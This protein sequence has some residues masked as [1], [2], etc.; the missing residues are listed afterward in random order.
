[1]MDFGKARAAM[2]EGQVRANDVTDTRLQQAMLTVPRELF[3]PKSRRSLA[4]M[5]ESVD[6]GEGR[7]L[8]DPRTF[9]KLIQALDVRP[10]DVVLDIGCATGYGAAVLSAMAETVIGL[11]NDEVLASSATHTL[12]EL[13]V[14]NAAIMCGDLAAGAPDHGPY[15]VILVSG[16]VEVVPDAWAEQL[17][18][19]GR[20][21]VVV[22]TG[23]M[24]RAMLYL[25]TG[26]HVSSRVVFDSTLPVMEGFTRPEEFVF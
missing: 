11:E 20:M 12:M 26:D 18:D 7:H 8:M 9:G 5:G 19:G 14:D 3:V 22:M 25:R 1:M 16:G 13:G 6:L 2:V 24:G 17:A 4:Y 23:P 15:D 21:G 10:G